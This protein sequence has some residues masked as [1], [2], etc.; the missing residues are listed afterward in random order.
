MTIGDILTQNMSFDILIM[1]IVGI[2]AIILQ[3]KRIKSR[4]HRREGSLLIVLL[5]AF[6]IFFNLAFIIDVFHVF[7][8][9]VPYLIMGASFL[10]AVFI[11]IW[12]M[13]KHTR[14]FNKKRL[15]LF[16]IIILTGLTFYIIEIATGIKELLVSDIAEF[17]IMLAIFIS[18]LDTLISFLIK[19][20]GEN[21]K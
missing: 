15:I 19:V 11:L 20:G 12:L 6:F 14:D 5:L 1:C 8:E 13:C 3:S 16:L 18:L 10:V 21:E 2:G 17:A 7:T 9:V 4:N